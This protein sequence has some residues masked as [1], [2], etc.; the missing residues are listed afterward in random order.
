MNDKLIAAHKARS[1]TQSQISD[2]LDVNY[3]TYQR[4]EA[5][6]ARPKRYHLTRLCEVFG[7]SAEELG[8]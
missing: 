6:Q 4:W 5:G 8:F 1:F 3:K 2:T 7:K